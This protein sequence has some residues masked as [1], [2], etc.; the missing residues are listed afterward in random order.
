[1]RAGHGAAKAVD[2]FTV[3]EMSSFNPGV[4]L[5]TPLENS[6]KAY[7]VG[8]PV[9]SGQSL[10]VGLGVSGAAHSTRLETIAFTLAFREPLAE[11]KKDVAAGEQSCAPYQNGVRLQSDLKIRQFIYDKAFIATTGEATTKNIKASPYSTFSEDITF[12]ASYGGSAT[13]VWKFARIS[14]NAD[15]PLANASRSKTDDLII[16]LSPVTPA[17]PTSAARLSQQG[18]NV[19]NAQITGS[20][21]ASAI[22]SSTR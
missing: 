9:V 7:P 3:D 21:T 16:T 14:V 6:L 2:F 17:T 1:L 4:D 15:T 22:Q 10:S 13:P 12:V 20:F 19:H 5:L 8:G 18:Q 11:A